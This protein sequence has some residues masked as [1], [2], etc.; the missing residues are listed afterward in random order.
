M[1]LPPVAPGLRLCYTKGANPTLLPMQSPP[2]WGL[3]S[4]QLKLLAAITM[5][6]DHIGVV[7]FPDDV[8]F[9]LVGRI[10]FPL[11][12]WLLVQG[13]AHTRDL[14]RYAIR[15]AILGLVS[16]P[17]YQLFFDINRLNI[18]FELLVGLG[19]LRLD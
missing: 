10:S 3:T 6:V 4:Y 7:F 9:R 13:E 19:C 17:I 5:L 8:R 12:I 2:L 1:S 18:L 14:G 11:F 16:Q 15:L